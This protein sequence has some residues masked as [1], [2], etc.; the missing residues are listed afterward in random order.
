MNVTLCVSKQSALKNGSIF[1]KTGNQA[2]YGAHR[3]Y[4]GSANTA[5]WGKIIMH[6][7]LSF[8]NQYKN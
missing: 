6:I 7:I 1:S 8:Y 5:A 3:L 4:Y 2:F